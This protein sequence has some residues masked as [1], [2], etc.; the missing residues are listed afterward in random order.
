MS[1]LFHDYFDG[2]MTLDQTSGSEDVPQFAIKPP[3]T[4]DF[5]E[6]L[7]GEPPLKRKRVEVT[8]ECRNVII[9][10]VVC[11]HLKDGSEKVSDTH[12]KT[13]VHVENASRFCDSLDWKYKH[14]Y[15][16]WKEVDE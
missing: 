11:K 4:C 3:E 9:A 14:V 12:F 15:A 2:M 7:V 8:V 16:K 5:R 10:D 6:E 1:R 13:Y